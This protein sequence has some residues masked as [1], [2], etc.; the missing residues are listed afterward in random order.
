MHRLLKINTKYLKRVCFHFGLTSR[1]YVIKKKKK[2][3]ILKND[4]HRKYKTRIHSNWSP[5]YITPLFLRL[6]INYL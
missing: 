6:V 5:Q 1:A 4:M 3:N 2:K